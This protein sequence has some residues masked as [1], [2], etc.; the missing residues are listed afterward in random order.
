MKTLQ[1]YYTE[2]IRIRQ[3]ELTKTKRSMAIV[4]ILRLFIV[5]LAGTTVYLFWGNAM[6]VFCIVLAAIILFLF[7]VVRHNQLFIK[8]DYIR[9]SIL[10]DS[11]ELK[12]I[13]YDFSAF[14]GYKERISS[15]HHF[16]LDL[17]IFGNK[18]LF[19]SLNRTCTAYGK[20]LLADWFEYPETKKQDILQRQEAVRELSFA[21]KLMQHFVVTGQLNPSQDTDLREVNEFIDF[22]T[23]FTNNKIWTF[24]TYVIPCIWL[25]LIVLM[26]VGVLPVT[27]TLGLAIVSGLLIGECRKKKIDALQFLVGKKEK[28]FSSYS[29]LIR[30]AESQ[31]FVSEELNSIRQEFYQENQS[32][33]EIL[34]QLSRLLGNLDL[35]FNVPARLLLNV[36]FL[37]DIRVSIKIEKWQQK[38]APLLKTWIEA[39][40]KYDALIS[41]GLFTHNHPAYVFPEITDAYFVFEGKNLGH[42]LMHR[43]VC[44][45]NDIEILNHPYFLIVTGANMAGKST[46]LRTLGVNYLLA[47]LGAPVCADSMKLCPAELITSLRTSDSLSDNE[48]YFFAE[49]KRLKMIIDELESGKKLFISLDE[50]LKGTN[51]VDKQKGSLALVQQ[52]ISLN[53]CG[54]IATHDLMLGSLAEKFPDKI[55]NYRFEADIT[56][57]ELRF[58]YQL[59]E[60]VAEN[61]NACFLM[62]KMG[63]KL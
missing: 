16:S 32:A 21:P 29:E 13:D 49:L 9:T 59:R 63:I 5:L 27:M 37:W 26:S 19:Q 15:L 8:R 36:M 30:I 10:F 60:G 2:D 34:R 38:N 54:I 56:G 52:F 50:I 28:M 11:N 53:A 41:L 48:S 14:D 35:R 17:D 6:A 51:S 44:V 23:Y 58:S 42:P 18:S 25:I 45:K 31:Q 7:F 33:S 39:L 12:A 3:A 43:D 22:P 1:S 24:L 57:D 55:K 46:Y 20:K 40:G 61:M 47:C 4:S 62:K